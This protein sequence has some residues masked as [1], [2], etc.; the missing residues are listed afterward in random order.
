MMSKSMS[1]LGSKIGAIPEIIK[2]R[3]NGFLFEPGSVSSI[4]KLIEHVIDNPQNFPI[5]SKNA[6]ETSKEY[7]IEK[8]SKSMLEVYSSVIHKTDKKL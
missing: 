5:M 2:D 1:V 8:M 3:S 6:L 4:Q 7:S